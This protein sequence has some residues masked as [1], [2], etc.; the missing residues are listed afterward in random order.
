MPLETKRWRLKAR[1]RTS[2]ESSSTRLE[3]SKPLLGSEKMKAKVQSFMQ[4]SSYESSSCTT[5]C[6]YALVHGTSN[7]VQADRSTFSAQSNAWLQIKKLSPR[8]YVNYMH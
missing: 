1:P 2:K 7:L 5:I 3:R 4:F 6:A 8:V